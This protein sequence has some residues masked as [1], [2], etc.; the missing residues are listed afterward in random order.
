MARSVARTGCGG[1]AGRVGCIGGFHDTGADPSPK[2]GAQHQDIR[3]KALEP[4]RVPT[5]NQ[6]PG[7]I[8]LGYKDPWDVGVPGADRQIYQA[9]RRRGRRIWRRRSEGALTCAQSCHV[10]AAAC[11]W[12]GR[13]GKAVCESRGIAAGAR[14]GMYRR[15]P[16]YGRR[17]IAEARCAASGYPRKGPGT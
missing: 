5:L 12:E 8:W 13:R 4:R 2:R 16:R 15:F 9:A 14:A 3:G 10:R 6:G 7:S 1:G 17:P 11:R